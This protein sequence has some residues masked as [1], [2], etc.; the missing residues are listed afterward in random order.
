[1][2]LVAGGGG[3]CIPRLDMTRRN[4]RD[5][6]ENKSNKIRNWANR[7]RMRR[8]KKG[9]DGC[10]INVHVMKLDVDA[11]ADTDADTD[12]SLLDRSCAGRCLHE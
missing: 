12:P 1:V 9:E 4:T 10:E 2:V 3:V 8:E 11:D 6:Q 5:R 7:S